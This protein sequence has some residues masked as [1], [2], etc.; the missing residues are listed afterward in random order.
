[1]GIRGSHCPARYDAASLTWEGVFDVAGIRALQ[2]CLCIRR[3]AR[4]PIG[5]LDGD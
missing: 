3:T 5:S 4:Q 2:L 1:M